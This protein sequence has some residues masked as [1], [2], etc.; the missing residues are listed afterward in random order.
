[1]YIWKKL[2]ILLLMLLSAACSNVEF[3]DSINRQTATKPQESDAQK[4]AAS[5]EDADMD[6]ESVSEPVMV[7]GAFLNCSEDRSL[8]VFEN[9]KSTMGCRIQDDGGQKRKD[10][11]P[12]ASDLSIFMGSE[13]IPA[14]VAPYD[15]Q[16]HWVAP[17]IPERAEEYAV[18]TTIAG[19][20]EPTTKVITTPPTPPSDD[21]SV[22]KINPDPEPT[23]PIN[24][25]ATSADTTPVENPPIEPDPPPIEVVRFTG[26]PDDSCT[27]KEYNNHEFY[28]CD[29]QANRDWNSAL[30]QCQQIGG[31][32]VTITSAAEN[33]KVKSWVP[34][35][36]YDYIWIGISAT[37]RLNALNFRWASGETPVFSDWNDGSVGSGF[38]AAQPSANNQCGMIDNVNQGERWNDTGCDNQTVTHYICEAVP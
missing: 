31:S 36:G 29:N 5:S 22:P 35:G 14:T 4:D 11:Q 9:A 30:N 16:W 2:S 27:K 23:A 38:K 8:T 15:S 12:T 21:N 13:A 18:S 7:G 34:P 26:D 24:S 20:P 28:V 6:N 32:L 33:D 10:V 1:M 19:I 25:V 17:F 3:S 37:T